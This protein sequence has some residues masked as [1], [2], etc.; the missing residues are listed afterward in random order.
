MTKMRHEP[1]TNM[2]LQIQITTLSHRPTEV[3]CCLHSHITKSYQYEKGFSVVSKKLFFYTLAAPH[4]CLLY[5][6]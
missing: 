4:Y 3:E 5:R 1:L 6:F 2:V